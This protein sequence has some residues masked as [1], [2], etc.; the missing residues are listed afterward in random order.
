[1]NNVNKMNNV[2]FLAYN[3][4]FL[5]SFVFSLI[6]PSSLSW[7]TCEPFLTYLFQTLVL[8]GALASEHLLTVSPMERM[9]TTSPEI[10]LTA[11]PSHVSSTLVAAALPDFSHNFSDITLVFSDGRVVYY[12]ALLYLISPWWKELLLQVPHCCSPSAAVFFSLC[13]PETPPCAPY[14]PSGTLL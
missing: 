8:S 7:N 1:M 12:R 2:I 11:G 9:K 14:S 10:G 4:F 3:F 6:I 5:I 13:P